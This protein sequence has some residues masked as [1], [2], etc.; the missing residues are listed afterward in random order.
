MKKEDVTLK[1]ILAI[2]VVVFGMG[3]VVF[4]EMPDLVLG[5]LLG[6][7]SAVLMYFFGSSTGSAAK[8]KVIQEI[9][10]K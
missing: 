1:N 10:N 8:D 9:T 4:V 3:A 2:F 5:A 6:N 7:I